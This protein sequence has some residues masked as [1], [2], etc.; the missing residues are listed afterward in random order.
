MPQRRSPDL[1]RDLNRFPLSRPPTR[2]IQT[3]VN[4]RQA[5]LAKSAQLL[6]EDVNQLFAAAENLQEPGVQLRSLVFEGVLRLEY[7]LESLQ[8]ASVVT[9]QLN[10]GYEHKPW[11]L[12]SVISSGSAARLPVAGLPMLNLMPSQPTSQF[13]GIWSVDIKKL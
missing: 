11:Q 5:S 3:K 4:P 7:G 12:E 2:T 9:T 10:L 8:K 6:Q 1:S 13:R